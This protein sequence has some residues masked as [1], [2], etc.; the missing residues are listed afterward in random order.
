MHVNYISS[1]IDLLATMYIASYIGTSGRNKGQKLV[2]HFFDD[3]TF[4]RLLIAIPLKMYS[5]IGQ[6]KWILVSQMLKLVGK[7]PMANCYF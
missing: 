5:K 2:S 7:W 6:P 1:L 3:R 4:C